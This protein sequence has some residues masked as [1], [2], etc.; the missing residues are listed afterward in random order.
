MLVV[1]DSAL[2]AF[3]APGGF[4]V[5]N[6][7]L[8]AA[9]KSPEE[10]AGVLAHEIQHVTLRHST[11]AVIREAPLRFALSSLSGG[12]METAAGVVGTLGALRYRRA[13]EAEADH[14]GLRVMD[15]ALID[16]RGMVSFMRG[17]EARRGAGSRFTSYV[18]THPRTADRIA[19]LEELSARGAGRWTSVLDSAAWH[20][21][22]GICH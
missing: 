18:S 9:A 20:R 8:V 16:P 13:D 12:G 1:R 22:K 7:G 10:L 17:L 21:V 2:N 11:R 3:A 14:Y 19:A 5:V 6:S 15:A 4:V